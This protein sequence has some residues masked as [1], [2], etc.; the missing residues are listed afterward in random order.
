MADL[1][2]D[3]GDS[4]AASCGVSFVTGGMVRLAA[5]GA[6]RPCQGQALWENPSNLALA[7]SLGKPFESAQR[8]LS[9]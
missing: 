6:L 5:E 4:D 1:T 7:S 3:A 2:L 8:G 9:G